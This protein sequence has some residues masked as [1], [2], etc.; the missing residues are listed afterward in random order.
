[1]KFE[2]Y[3]DKMSP[4]DIQ[5]LN[6]VWSITGRDCDARS[7]KYLRKHVMRFF[8][9]NEYFR[10]AFTGEIKDIFI[11]KEPQEYLKYKVLGLDLPYDEAKEYLREHYILFEE[12][13]PDDFEEIIL[14]YLKLTRVS[15]TNDNDA[16]AVASTLFL[17]LILMLNYIQKN[18][19]DIQKMFKGVDI[20]EGIVSRVHFINYLRT[21]HLLTD[22]EKYINTLNLSRW[23]NNKFDSMIDFYRFITVQLN[24]KLIF[25]FFN[26]IMKIL[27]DSGKWI[28]IQEFREIFH[29]FEKEVKIGIRLG[30]ILTKRYEEEVYMKLSPEALCMITGKR[31]SKWNSKEVLVT[32]LKEVFVPYDFD[33]FV[34]QIIDYFG[35]T[36]KDKNKNS[37]KYCDDYFIISDIANVQ[38]VKR[39]VFTFAKLVKCIEEYCDN[40]PSIIRDEVLL[41]K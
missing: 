22:D 21:R 28:K 23:I 25:D 6:K 20:E 15:V 38:G 14:Q 41:G 35:D 9:K 3:Y 5:N 2:K 40:I 16:I 19:L 17:K 10:K 18:K 37:I 11:G 31:P 26:M 7:K 4:I 24:A 39:D 13:I 36:E 34:I 27:E 32:P 33:P 8:F 12:A 29:K 30:L 1:M